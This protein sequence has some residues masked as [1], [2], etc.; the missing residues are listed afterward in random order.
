M[1][2]GSTARNLLKR[3]LKELTQNPIEGF[4]AGEYRFF[5]VNTYSCRTEYAALS[6]QTL[7]PYLVPCEMLG[8]YLVNARNFETAVIS[9]ASE[10]VIVGA[11]SSG[12]ATDASSSHTA[13]FECI[14]RIDATGVCWRAWRWINMHIR[15]LLFYSD[16]SVLFLI[17]IISVALLTHSEGLIEDNL[18]EWRVVIIGWAN[19]SASWRSQSLLIL[20]I[21]IPA[22]RLIRF[23]EYRVLFR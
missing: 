22:V 11:L 9:C 23:S 21:P 1:N 8:L 12:C 6:L 17:W 20:K 18:L 10:S 5:K 13:L 15:S 2:S 16:F 14:G 3:E 4:S 7:L 19:T